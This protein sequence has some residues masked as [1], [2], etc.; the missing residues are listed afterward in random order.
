MVLPRTHPSATCFFNAL[1][2]LADVSVL[3]GLPLVYSFSLLFRFPWSEYI[4][5]Y[6]FRTLFR[7][8]SDASN[9][10]VLPIMLGWTFLWSLLIN[11]GECHQVY[12]KEWPQGLW[13]FNF[14]W[15]DQ[16][17]LRF[18]ETLHS[19]GKTVSEVGTPSPRTLANT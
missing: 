5:I 13:N 19:P 1:M 12:T 14:T 9:S 18:F 2:C 17:A 3:I 11:T 7:N 15:Y 4:T 10:T 16:V 8:I 6:V